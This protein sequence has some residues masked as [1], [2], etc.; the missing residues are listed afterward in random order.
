MLGKTS[1]WQRLISNTANIQLI[2]VG[3]GTAIEIE[4]RN[5]LE[6]LS[7]TDSDLDPDEAARQPL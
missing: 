1:V 3:I 7:N 6:D 5:S 4:N 2:G